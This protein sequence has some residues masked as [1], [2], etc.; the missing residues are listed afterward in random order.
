MK[1]DSCENKYAAAKIEITKLEGMGFTLAGLH[2]L[3]GN[4]MLLTQKVDGNEERIRISID[5]EKTSVSGESA[6]LLYSPNKIAPQ[7]VP[8]QDNLNERYRRDEPIVLTLKN[9]VLTVEMDGKMQNL[10][11]IKAFTGVL[12][13]KRRLTKHALD[14]CCY[15]HS[16]VASWY[17]FFVYYR[18]IYTHTSRHCDNCN[19]GKRN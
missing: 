18:G 10:Q 19:I 15:S 1:K 12:F 3:S 2:G 4:L 16:L 8:L 17:S 6:T 11:G 9:N 5:A 7:S 14:N 13:N